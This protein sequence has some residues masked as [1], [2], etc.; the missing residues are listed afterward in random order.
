MKLHPLLAIATLAIACA[1]LPARAQS[2]A[3]S[4][5]AEPQPLT[6][7]KGVS[8]EDVKDTGNKAIEKLLS[9]FAESRHAPG[10]KG[11]ILLPLPRDVDHG[12]FSQQLEA[13]LSQR[14]ADK[15]LKI[16]TRNDKTLAQIFDFTAWAQ[17]FQEAIDEKTLQKLGGIVDAPAIISP[18]LDI[19]V[20]ERGNITARANMRV[21]ERRTAEIPPGV[22]EGYAQMKAMPSNNDILRWSGYTLAGLIALFLLLKFLGAIRAAS[23]PR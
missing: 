22:S 8:I 7:P 17:N 1:A 6:L 11:F 5:V 13:E 10:A 9:N 14:F 16:Y 12:Y 21:I 18:R 4:P 19:T 2:T 15:G 3:S 20:D 23:R